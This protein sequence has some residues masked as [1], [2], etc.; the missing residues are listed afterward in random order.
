MRKTHRELEKSIEVR[1]LVAELGFLCRMR[2]LGLRELLIDLLL[3][4]QL[5]LDLVFPK[6]FS[7]C[8]SDMPCLLLESSR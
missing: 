6:D 5:C 1:C 7:V 3:L 2:G 4:G 8:Q